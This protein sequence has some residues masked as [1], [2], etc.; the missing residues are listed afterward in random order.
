VAVQVQVSYDSDVEKALA[1]LVE[2]AQREPRALGDAQAPKAFLVGFGDNGI[3]LELG[4]WIND[5]HVGQLDLKSSINRAIVKA[6]AA[7][8]IEIPF[9]RR[10]IRILDDVSPVPPP[11]GRTPVR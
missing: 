6:F 5:P 2:I 1:L 3:N 7:N 11:V 9:P 4:V 8:G 10:D